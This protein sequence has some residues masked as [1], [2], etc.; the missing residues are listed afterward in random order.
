M[1]DRDV[2]ILKAIAEL[3]TMSSKAIEERTG[4]PKST[5][6]YR[7]D[8]LKQSGV[9]EDDLF[10]VDFEQLGLGLTVITEVLAEFEEG[11]H[12]E[13][14]EKLSEIE[15]VNSVFFTMGDTDFIVIAHLPDREQIEGLVNAYEG[16][17]QIKRTSSSFVIT[18]IKDGSTPFADYDLETLQSINRS[19]S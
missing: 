18:T 11:Y 9:I 1:D 17:D 6:H 16:I 19:E 13:V 10:T 8:N 14:G 3:G 7:I 5:V 12:R 15:G 2:E 4:I